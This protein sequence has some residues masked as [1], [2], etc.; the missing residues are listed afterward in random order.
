MTND[1]KMLVFKIKK[2]SGKY[3]AAGL[4]VFIIIQDL[5]W[6][7]LSRLVF[8][9]GDFFY[10]VSDFDWT[11]FSFMLLV[12]LLQ[13]LLVVSVM[14]FTPS[15]PKI[16]ISEQAK[17]YLYYLAFFIC[18]TILLLIDTNSRYTSGSLT[19]LSGII[20]YFGKAYFIC[21]ALFYL[22]GMHNK[23]KTF[24]RK[25]F[26]ILLVFGIVLVDGLSVALAV[27]LLAFAGFE[28]Y[29]IKIKNWFF[30]AA[31]SA[32]IF[33][34]GISAKWNQLPDYVNFEFLLRWAVSRF[35]IQ[36]EQ[37]YA[38]LSYDT[39]IK[40]M[41]DYWGMIA[42]SNIN[43]FELVFEGRSEFTPP[44]NVSE[45]LFF[46]MK[47]N[48]GSGSSPGLA[49]GLAFHGILTA[50]L[51]VILLLILLRAYFDGF[52]TKPDWIKVWSLAFI[53]KPLHANI[54]EYFIA[55]SPVLAFAFVFFVFSLLRV[56]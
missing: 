25:G 5:F 15:L 52:K 30:L 22:R 8:S 28:L 31:V 1:N 39:T 33:W 21:F 27:V 35:S 42:Q 47:G 50:L 51:P 20:Y 41:G 16:Y 2:S 29:R 9:Q 6:F 37:L 18:A 48:F 49:L 53:I 40:D 34:V 45:A 36:A 55:I 44:R 10:R 38:F 26:L 54:S 14:I 11:V 23:E 7:L 56:R 32:C 24:S 12:F 19:G 13:L 4:L 3:L 17:K 46:D 43:R